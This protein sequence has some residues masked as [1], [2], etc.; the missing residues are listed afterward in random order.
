MF[1]LSLPDGAPIQPA[2]AILLILGS[3]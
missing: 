1:Y 2:L 3:L